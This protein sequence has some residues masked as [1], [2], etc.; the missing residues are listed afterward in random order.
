MPSGHKLPIL[1]RLYFGEE[2]KGWAICGGESAGDPQSTSAMIAFDAI[3]FECSAAVI[4]RIEQLF[5]DYKEFTSDGLSWIRKP[6]LG[7]TSSLSL[8]LAWNT[9]V[10]SLAFAALRISFL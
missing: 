6:N 7:H 8:S 2:N 1:Y 4:L 9:P 10:R 3:F 5:F